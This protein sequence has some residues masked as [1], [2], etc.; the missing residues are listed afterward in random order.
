MVLQ[1]WILTV[2]LGWVTLSLKHPR[3]G[4]AQLILAGTKQYHGM[5][6]NIGSCSV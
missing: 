2:E 6:F 4:M 3:L 5:L 1:E